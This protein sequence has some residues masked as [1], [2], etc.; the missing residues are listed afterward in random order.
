MS[1]H[2]HTTLKIITI[3]AT[4]PLKGGELGR[5]VALENEKIPGKS[6][7]L[8]CVG[9]GKSLVAAKPLVKN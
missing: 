6:S 9:K 3:P 2:N 1:S 5:D 8:I 4:F 7:F